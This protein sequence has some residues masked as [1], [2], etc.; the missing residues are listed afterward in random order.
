M[1]VQASLF[2]DD[3]GAD[4]LEDDDVALPSTSANVTS[5]G[6]MPRVCLH[7]CVFFCVCVCVW[8]CFWL[9]LCLCLSRMYVCVCLCLC[10][11]VCVYV[12]CKTQMCL[13]CKRDEGW[14][15]GE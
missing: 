3:P 4:R 11:C 1:R 14:G 6:G 12:S 15:M 13:S 7:M 9:C 2:D 10:V 5:H 8:H